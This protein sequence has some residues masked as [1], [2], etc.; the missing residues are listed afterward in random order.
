MAGGG[1]YPWVR[2]AMEGCY[3]WYNGVVRTAWP[4]GK[5][6]VILGN[7]S[8]QYNSMQQ[9]RAPGSKILLY[10]SNEPTSHRQIKKINDRNGPHRTSLRSLENGL[11]LGRKKLQHP[12]VSSVSSVSFI[13]HPVGSGDRA[14]IG[15][16]SISRN[17]SQATLR[18]RDVSE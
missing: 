3:G 9:T 5:S 8:I 11:L 12:R 10:S 13:H 14:D 18:E 6:V 1:G 4:G 16:A 17:T 2:L 15:P 7:T